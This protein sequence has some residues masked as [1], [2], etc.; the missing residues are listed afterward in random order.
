MSLDVSADTKAQVLA[1]AQAQGLSVDDYLKQLML[2]AE[3]DE[4]EFVAAVEQGLRDLEEGRVHPARA[5]LAELG[6]K[7]GLSR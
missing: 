7:L 4:Q 3:E 2:E 6:A 1:K 5:A